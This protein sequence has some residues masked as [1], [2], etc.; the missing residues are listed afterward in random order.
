MIKNK[1]IVLSVIIGVF[2]II[3]FTVLIFN[4]SFA[5]DNGNK[6]LVTCNKN[7]VMKDDVVSCSV[8]GSSDL[9]VSAV[10]LN[11]ELPNDF[12]MLNFKI[13]T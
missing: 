1:K 8:K 10:A 9:S 5:L 4:K 7:V 11:I 12:E 3:L 6:L 2:F 13:D